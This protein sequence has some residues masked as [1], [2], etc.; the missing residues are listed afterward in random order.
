[1]I[2]FQPGIFA[3]CIGVL[4]CR[5]IAGTRY[6]TSHTLYFCDNQTYNWFSGFLVIPIILITVFIIP[7]VVLWAMGRNE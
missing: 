7:G 4:A 5:D 3:E 6:V 2:Y 1:M